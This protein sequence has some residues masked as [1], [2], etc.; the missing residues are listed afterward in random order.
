VSVRSAANVRAYRER[1]RRARHLL[2]FSVGTAGVVNLVS[3][4][5]PAERRR[6]EDLRGILPLSA[7]HVATTA[8]AIAGVALIVLARQ[9]WRGKHVAM[10]V[11]VALLLGSVLL[12]LAKGF[13]FEEATFAFVLAA[14]LV[15]RRRDFAARSDPASLARFV[16]TAPLLVAGAYVYGVGALYIR[17]AD[18]SPYVT[19]D[20]KSVV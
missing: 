7:S 2:A 5:L 4:I 1:P 20:R 8:T 13:D 3:A 18:V 11:G 17:H 19:L 10:V 6:L 9:L 16:D 12:H 15:W 14:A